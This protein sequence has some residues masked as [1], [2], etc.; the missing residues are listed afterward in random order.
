MKTISV[1][2]MVL[3][4]SHVTSVVRSHFP[5][6]KK[7][8]IG[9]KDC[10]F[11]NLDELFEFSSE[12]QA[13]FS[14]NSTRASLISGLSSLKNRSIDLSSIKSINSV[15]S[16][17]NTAIGFIH[18]NTDFAFL[19]TSD[20]TSGLVRVSVDHSLTCQDA[21]VDQQSQKA[22]MACYTTTP[23]QNYTARLFEI[24]LKTSK[25]VADADIHLNLRI[26]ASPRLR[27]R[28]AGS[29]SMPV[30][31]VY[32]GWMPGD[33]HAGAE[34]SVCMGLNRKDLLFSCVRFDGL[35]E[36]RTGKLK[37][38]AGVYKASELSLYVVGIAGENG[39][40]VITQCRFST[41]FFTC[42]GIKDSDEWAKASYLIPTQ[43]NK[44]V[45]IDQSSS[46]A[47][48][49]KEFTNTPIC[50][51]PVTFN[52]PEKMSIK[53]ISLTEGKLVMALHNKDT[54]NYAST[55]ILNYING[56][57]LRPVVN[58]VGVAIRGR[59]YFV[60]PDN[61]KVLQLSDFNN[62]GVKICAEYVGEPERV[63]VSCSSPKSGS[64]ATYDLDIS[65]QSNYVG[66]IRINPEYETSPI[67][68]VKGSI[69]SLTFTRESISG[70]GVTVQLPL[71]SDGKPVFKASKVLT[72][73][74]TSMELVSDDED[75]KNLK[76]MEII[77]GF[78]IGLTV[79][80]KAVLYSC[81]YGGNLTIEC[82]LK[83]SKDLQSS[84]YELASAGQLQDDWSYAL[85]KKEGSSE[86]LAI[87]F[88]GD[89]IIDHTFDIKDDKTSDNP[90]LFDA[91]GFVSARFSQSAD[92]I[93]A[94]SMTDGEIEGY[95]YVS[96]LIY[97][98]ETKAFRMHG[99]ILAEN[100]SAGTLC[101]PRLRVDETKDGLFVFSS[102]TQ[103]N[104]L[105][106]YLLP[107]LTSTIEETSMLEG[108]RITRACFFGDSL[109][110]GTYNTTSKEQGIVMTSIGEG[111]RNKEFFGLSE[112]GIVREPTEMYCHQDAKLL[113]IAFSNDDEGYM[114][115][116]AI[117]YMDSSKRA[118][119]R[120]HSVIRDHRA[121]LL[122]YKID[123]GLIMARIG[124]EEE[125]YTLDSYIAM[126]SSPKIEIDT[127]TTTGVD[128]PN[129]TITALN[130]KLYTW[131]NVTLNL[132]D[133]INTTASIPLMINLIELDENI[134]IKPLSKLSVVEG[135]PVNLSSIVNISGTVAEYAVEGPDSNMVAVKQPI[136]Q[137]STSVNYDKRVVT[138]GDGAV[139]YRQVDP[140]NTL[141]TLL[142]VSKD[143]VT[144]G[145][146][147]ALEPVIEAT[148]LIQFEDGW[149]MAF[150]SRSRSGSTGKQIKILIIN[151]ETKSTNLIQIG[152]TKAHTLQIVFYQESV[153]LVAQEDSRAVLYRL[154][155][156]DSKVTK[157][158]SFPMSK[159]QLV[160][161]PR[162]SKD[163]KG[164]F[165]IGV[166]SL[167]M[168]LTLTSIELESTRTVIGI[169]KTISDSSA[170]PSM[171]IHALTCIDQSSGILCLVN[172]EGLYL[173][174]LVID[175]R[176]SAV[177]YLAKYQKP[178]GLID[179][180]VAASH[181]C[182]VMT[183]IDSMTF[184]QKITVWR[185][186]RSE[187]EVKPIGIHPTNKKVATRGFRLG[188][189]SSKT[190]TILGYDGDR[191]EIMIGVNDGGSSITRIS[192]KE[193]TLTFLKSSADVSK[194]KLLLSGQTQL[195]VDLEPL[196]S[197]T[198]K[199]D[200]MPVPKPSSFF[201][202]WWGTL[203]IMLILLIL[204]CLACW[205]YYINISKSDSEHDQSYVHID[206]EE[207][208]LTQHNDHENTIDQLTDAKNEKDVVVRL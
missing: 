13:S 60:D 153:L 139:V 75:S 114:N 196:I 140:K 201:R 192:A 142:S 44:L 203:L 55:F 96:F 67:T 174:E 160:A 194:L 89:D 176:E 35:G 62:D 64:V 36:D 185:K 7:I 195:N 80:G 130:D 132:V 104:K 50:T 184:E 145:E 83:A 78:I 175:A 98:P 179:E 20:D 27:L 16:F 2:C 81:L 12:D 121:G 135:T 133:Y 167:S 124:E 150:V 4:A 49:C 84:D 206:D 113:A 152:E 141:L 31:V 111:D 119:L 190:V 170:L 65:K 68:V 197:I 171:R 92:A 94:I 163:I 155:L 42:N 115:N 33:G 48:V 157:V 24:D 202:S 45:V 102:C 207:G 23:T 154:N 25:I 122:P 162:D 21:A 71:M 52:L 165:L 164:P 88:H 156:I 69:A 117:F 63:R 46:S 103:E 1:L 116:T 204:I 199:N 200:D 87:I 82:K 28:I 161:L 76:A 198:K 9:P 183:A 70:N 90:R 144:L 58:S 101:I 41:G 43:G 168:K 125:G 100:T 86:V 99:K 30:V 6:H 29:S 127:S 95:A 118:D 56:H 107:D 159:S 123:S 91:V 208:H 66:Q 191:D 39:K 40:L 11:L 172:T 59:Y 120:Y 37:A 131:S 149:L 181:E 138:F 151:P 19:N 189:P 193:P 73:N 109:V 22:Y 129:P 188:Q 143:K 148:C 205:C 79:K 177:M 15:Y 51:R 112:Y 180:K 158:E 77:E 53:H 38:I 136:T 108:A 61:L 147:R 110:L 186:E 187:T 14:I 5:A 74:K 54:G 105:Y 3:L 57:E 32:S 178:S 10:V 182:I 106:V 18:Q 8:V 146:T 169:T 173:Y 137:L 128:L 97:D 47:K 26:D 93:I 166:S 34:V 85:L 17:A 72:V 126:N 134:T